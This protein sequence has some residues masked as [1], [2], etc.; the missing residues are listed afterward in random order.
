[1]ALARW[2]SQAERD[3]EHIALYVGVT[4]HRPAAAVRLIDRIMETVDLLSRHGT[5][6]T[7]RDDLGPGYRVFSV[8]AT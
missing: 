4:E 5:M 6:G 1:M 3:F 8:S 2:T 7:T